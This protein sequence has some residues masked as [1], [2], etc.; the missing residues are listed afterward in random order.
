M[1]TL[2][3]TFARLLTPFLLLAFFPKQYVCSPLLPL[4]S[5]SRPHVLSPFSTYVMKLHISGL[6]TS[7]L[8]DKELGGTVLLVLALNSPDASEL[9]VDDLC[10]GDFEGRER[11]SNSNTTSV[12]TLYDPQEA[13]EAKRPYRKDRPY[14]SSGGASTSMS[15]AMRSADIPILLPA[16]PRN[17]TLSTGTEANRAGRPPTCKHGCRR[18]F[19]VCG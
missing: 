6:T 13:D 12:R 19:W 3:H 14:T 10:A 11:E 7:S 8:C 9:D 18:G 15:P 16:S 4:A 2:L 1:R 17:R 5:P